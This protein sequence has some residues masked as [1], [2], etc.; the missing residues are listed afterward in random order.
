MLRKTGCLA[1]GLAE[2]H[3]ASMRPQRNAAENRPWSKK[4]MGDPSASM[5]P[6]RNAA[7]NNLLFYLQT[8]PAMLQ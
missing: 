5:R 7:E 6:Q 3:D 4:S 2:R 1:V 8:R